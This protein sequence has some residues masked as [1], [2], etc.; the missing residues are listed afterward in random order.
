[1]SGTVT[2]C[3]FKNDIMPGNFGPAPNGLAESPASPVLSGPAAA[4]GLIRDQVERNESGELDAK[5]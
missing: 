1:M 5:G 3:Q 4:A 2:E